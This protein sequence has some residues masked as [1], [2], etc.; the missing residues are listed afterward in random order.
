MG[1]TGIIVRLL[2]LGA[3]S[4]AVL[5][6]GVQCVSTGALAGVLI[7]FESNEA[8]GPL[9]LSVVWIGLALAVGF[10]GR[11]WNA[12]VLPLLGFAALL[13]YGVNSEN[14]GNEVWAINLTLVHIAEVVACGVGVHQGRRWWREFSER[15]RPPS[16]LGRRPE[17]M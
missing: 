13:A 14:Y 8:V 11:S 3:L 2:G 6:I 17:A 15:S 1:A 7:R 5:V 4:R 10:L 12:L 16:E 9:G